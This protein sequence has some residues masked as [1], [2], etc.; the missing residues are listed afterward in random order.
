MGSGLL[1]LM[2]DLNVVDLFPGLR[3]QETN[4]ARPTHVHQDEAVLP[5]DCDQRSHLLILMFFSRCMA[6]VTFVSLLTFRNRGA[7]FADMPIA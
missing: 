1:G 5:V 3:Y 7:L 4:C 6:A 2:H